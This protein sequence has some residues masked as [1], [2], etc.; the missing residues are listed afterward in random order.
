MNAHVMFGFYKICSS[1]IIIFC[2]V[3]RWTRNN[4]H[5]R[6]KMIAIAIPKRK[7]V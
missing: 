1:M 7:N 2:K 4:D 6:N 3:T 5:R